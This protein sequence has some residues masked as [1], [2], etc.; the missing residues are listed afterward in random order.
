MSF[1]SL[2]DK[3]LYYRSLTDYRLMPNCYVVCMLDGRRFSRNI[4]NKFEKPFSD[5]FIDMM[6]QTAKYLC[7]NVMTCKFAYVQSDEI[8]LVLSDVNGENADTFFG[9]RLCKLQSILASMASSKFNQLMMLYNIKHCVENGEK[10]KEIIS[11]QKLFEFDCKCWNLPQHNDV[12]AWILYR[13]NDCIKNS[14]QQAAQTYLPH[15]QLVGLNTD[16]QIELLFNEKNIDWNCF[17]NGKKYG[18]FIYKVE[19]DFWNQEMQLSYVRNV[20]NIFDAYPLNDSENRE[21]FINLNLF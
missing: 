13:Q 17:D 16:K 5:A 7:E 9:Y 19:E 15:K 1:K 3:C 6:N 21:Q 10:I 11:N 4:K 8:T 12:I 2:E 18:R 20:W 14:K